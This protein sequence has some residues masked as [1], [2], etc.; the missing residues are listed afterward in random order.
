MQHLDMKIEKNYRG[1]GVDKWYSAIDVTFSS[2][3]DDFK[4][5]LENNIKHVNISSFNGWTK[6]NL[7]SIKDWTFLEGLSIQLEQFDPTI[8]YELENLESLD[9]LG[10]PLGK[11]DLNNFVNL[12]DLNAS[13]KHINNLDACSNLEI[14]ML[15]SYD[16]QSLNELGNKLSLTELYLNKGK[17]ASFG[18][19]ENLENLR[20]LTMV[21]CKGTDF[22]ELKINNKY[23]LESLILDKVKPIFDYEPIIRFNELKEFSIYKMPIQSF[24]FLSKISNLEKLFIKQCNLSKK[25]KDFVEKLGIAECYL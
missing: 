7:S 12:R 14:L 23:K 6:D 2:K 13:Y 1:R 16:L 9:L 20:E 3:S 8:L 10:K 24:E 25:E 19:M 21:S 15:S 18:N 22:N 11:L 4:F 17:L 5:C